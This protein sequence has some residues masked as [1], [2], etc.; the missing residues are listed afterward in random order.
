MPSKTPRTISVILIVLILVI[1]TVTVY[2]ISLQTKTALKGSVQENLISVAGI[3]A[4]EINGDAFARLQTG[5]ENAVDFSRIRDQLRRIKEA[6]PDIRYIYTMRKNG[7]AVEFVVDGDYGYSKDAAEIGETYPQAE[8]ELLSGFLGPSA[9]SEFTTDQWGTVLSGY[10][11]IRDSTG[12]VVG[13]VGVDMNSSLVMAK[14]DSINMIL[15]LI[16][17]IAMISVTLGLIVVERRRSIDEQKLEESEKKYRLLFEQ[18]G[19][20]I[21]ILEA[22][23]EKQGKIIAAN[24]AAAKMHGYSV[25]EML[26]KTIADLYPPET[27]KD[28]P[29]RFATLL[30]GQVLNIESVHVKKDGALF[31]IEI[32][33]TLVNLGTQKYVLA[34]DRDITERKTGDEALQQVTKKLALLNS[35]TF[36]DIQNAIF[37][38]NAFL[39]LDKTISGDKNG[40]RYLDREEESIRN[41]IK[42]LNFAKSYQDLGVKPPRWQ[43]VN[44]AFIMGI[45]HLDFSAIHRV[46][47]VENLEIYA[48]SLLERVFFTFADNIIHHAKTATQ[49]TMGYQP[50]GD[51]LIISFEDNGVGIPDPLKEKIFE[52]GFGKQKG[53][54]SVPSAG[55]SQYYWNYNQGDGD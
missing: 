44:Q 49:V 41:I 5:D 19:D 10:S 20:S 13:I 7:D 35:V 31:P 26:T 47:H 50:N 28:L 14:L 12:A 32:N 4:S 40:N 42:S 46:V 8:P 43:N 33:A 55:D 34:T 9:D 16:G 25:E 39:S 51:H 17:I 53:M 2:S 54:E 24:T 36:N 52:R 1:T 27:R 21:L 38:L 15:Y 37:T 29:G 11:P 22:E 48:D 3:A 30:N 23:G 45:S 18:A 6:N